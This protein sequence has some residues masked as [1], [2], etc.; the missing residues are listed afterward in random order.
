MLVAYLL[1]NV[2][3]CV[4]CEKERWIGRIVIAVVEVF[5]DGLCE[6]FNR[7]TEGE[8]IREKVF[9]DFEGMEV[10]GQIVVLAGSGRFRQLRSH[11]GRCCASERFGLHVP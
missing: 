8:V 6:V 9:E 10:W 2:L 1:S 5:F 7:L 4:P 11:I 3:E